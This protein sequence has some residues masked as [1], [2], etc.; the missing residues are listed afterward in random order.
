MNKKP[1]K[2]NFI[3]VIENIRRGAFVEQLN[4]KLGEVVQ[5]VYATDLK[6][7]ITVKLD[8]SS[9]NE[10]QMIVAPSVKASVPVKSVGNAIFFGT[11][12]GELRRDDP[13][14]GALNL[15]DDPGGSRN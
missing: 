15:E 11:V 3:P 1:D 7:S 6:G 8:I 12:D 5:A 14:Q 9:N 2:G 13:R 4:A 10:G